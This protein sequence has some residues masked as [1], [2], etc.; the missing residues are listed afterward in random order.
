MLFGMSRKRREAEK[1]E[2]S[3]KSRPISLHALS[4]EDAVKA[5][6]AT[7]PM[8][9]KPKRQRTTRGKNPNRR[10]PS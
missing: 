10:K 6:T 7:P 1:P 9:E 5:L 8:T 2:E 3:T 4:F